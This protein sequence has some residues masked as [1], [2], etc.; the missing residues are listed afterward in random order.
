MPMGVVPK[1]E[2]NNPEDLSL[3]AVLKRILG[4]LVF[5]VIIIYNI[6]LTILAII[7]HILAIFEP[8]GDEE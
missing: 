8:Q 2:N 3:G 4:V 7:F 5:T 1:P 6:S